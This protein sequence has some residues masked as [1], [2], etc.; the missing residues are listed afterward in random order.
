M[1]VN[2]GLLDKHIVLA[3]A[4]VDMYAK[5]GIMTKAKQV[6]DS[7]SARDVVSWNALISGYIQAGQCHEALDCMQRI[8]NE[9]LSLNSVTFICILKACA[10]IGAINKGKQIHE[11]IM[12][13]GL[14]ETDLVLGNALIDM[15]ARCGMVSQA[16]EVLEDLPTRDVV[17]WNT[18]ICGYVQY[19]QNQEALY[20]FDR[21]Q[22]EGLTPDVVT[23][24]CILKACGN[25]G[26]ID[27]GKQ[28][29]EDILKA[30]FLAK[31]VMLVAAVVVNVKSW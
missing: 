3:T 19:A 30:G 29:H 14:L 22:S 11:R 25:I 2:S 4:L 20:S 21:M 7:L 12:N 8:Y 9:C 23:F 17:S 1:I 15:Y 6:L 16:R 31:D 18:L 24:M 13:S 26:A 5:C 28:I 10:T 27:K